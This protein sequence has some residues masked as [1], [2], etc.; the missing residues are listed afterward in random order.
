[1]IDTIIKIYFLSNTFLAGY[2]FEK[3]YE[4]ADT[5]KEK[6]ICYVWVFATWLFGLFIVLFTIIYGLMVEYLFKKLDRIFQI[7]FLFHYYFT[8][9]W[10]NVDEGTLYRINK[11]SLNIR[12]KNTL[13]D[14]IYRYGVKL[15]N[16]RNSY[17]YKEMEPQF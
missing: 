2:Y 15:I 12:N 7:R 13:K 10:H 14:R 6:S 17:V 16:K 5:L 8:K 1:M 3:Q 4:Y 9:E 11:V